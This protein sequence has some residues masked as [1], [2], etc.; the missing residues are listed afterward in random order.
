MKHIKYVLVLLSSTMLLF[1]HCN[2]AKRTTMSVAQIDRIVPT[3]IKVIKDTTHYTYI[4]PNPTPPK[5]IDTKDI[6]QQA[7]LELKAMLLG[8]QTPD[9]ERAVY[10]SENPYHNNQYTYQ[11][12]QEMVNIPLA[13]IQQIIASNDKSDTMNFDAKVGANGT[14]KMA[15]MRFLPKE[16]KELYKKALSNWAIFTYITDTLTIRLKDNNNLFTFYHLPFAYVTNDPFGKT[17]WTNTQV[18]NLLTNAEQGNC[19]SLTAFFKILSNRLNTGTRLCTAPQHVYI[20]HR[21][22]KGDYYNIELATAGFPRDGTLQTLTYTTNE[23]LKNGIALRDYTERQ[24]IGLCMV[25]LAKS[26]EH[27]YETQTDTFLLQCAETVLKYDSLNLSA[28]LLKQQVLDERVNQFA[29]EK[30]ISNIA[31]LKQ[32]KSILN[33]IDELEK[34]TALLFRLGYRQ[35]PLDMQQIILSGNYPK[36]FKDQ[37]PSPYSDPRISKDEKLGK[38]SALYGGLFKEVFEQQPTEQYRHFVFDTKT[39]KLKNINTNAL[40]NELIDPVAFAY[41]FGARFY[42]ARLGRFTSIDPLQAKYPSIS[43]YA[44]VANNP[45]LFKDLDGRKIII[46]YKDVNGKEQAYEYKAGIQPSFKNAIIDKV[47]EAAVY[48]MHSN[49]GAEIWNQLSTSDAVLEIRIKEVDEI[50]GG[51]NT[52]TAQ[53]EQ[54]TSGPK[55]LG[56]LLWDPNT[57][58]SFIDGGNLLGD[59]SPSTFILHELGHA[60]EYDNAIKGGNQ[61]GYFNNLADDDA[62][63]DNPEEKRNTIEVENVY[64]REINAWEQKNGGENPSY[65]PI[66]NNHLLKY[67]PGNKAN[68]N[69]V[70]SEDYLDYRKRESAKGRTFDDGI[71]DQK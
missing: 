33:T 27:Y 24:S 61:L 70:N 22:T 50:D 14:F 23:A 29:K 49:K 5:V 47:H 39:K 66:R 51:S 42:D 64:I 13:Y 30:S 69:R 52:F 21:D 20:Q 15:D 57:N 67:H 35:M 32:D 38:Y 71:K 26:Y 25:N 41:D 7:Y 45:I 53:M 48:N 1:T 18:I 9:F 59:A 17:D 19:F 68:V 31:Q 37:N 58:A 56:V 8:T 65:Q 36:E 11:Q 34:H 3:P 54:A 44:F 60:Q 28:L 43:P 4:K 2:T 16:K 10:L 62:Q 40:E 12:F 6:Y 55:K 46:Y 63:Y